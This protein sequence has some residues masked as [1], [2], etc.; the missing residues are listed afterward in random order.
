MPFSLI[1]IVLVLNPSSWRIYTI[2]LNMINWPIFSYKFI[3]FPK[4]CSFNNVIIMLLVTVNVLFDAG[5]R[6]VLSCSFSDSTGM[7]LL[8]PKDFTFFIPAQNAFGA[9]VRR[10]LFITCDGMH[11][12]V[13]YQLFCQQ[14]LSVECDFCLKGWKQLS[15]NCCKWRWHKGGGGWS[16][17]SRVLED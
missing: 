17:W 10:P 15:P 14:L 9:V 6:P 13:K 3:L 12:I 16:T 1:L 11:W 7:H 4:T 5:S 2:V 8:T